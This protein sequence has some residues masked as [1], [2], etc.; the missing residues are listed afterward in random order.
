MARNMTISNSSKSI[1]NQFEVDLDIQKI[2]DEIMVTL[3]VPENTKNIT[4]SEFRVGYDNSRVIFDRIESD[5][6]LQSFSA[7][8]SSYVKLGSISTDGSQNLNGGIEYK[9]YF[10]ETNNLDSFLGLVSIL[11]VELVKKD[12]TQIGV[13][14][15]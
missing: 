2:E 11:K 5:S 7:K 12:G 3:T 10:K 8:R 6:D 15:K 4:G 1:Q 9:I 13:I 14:V